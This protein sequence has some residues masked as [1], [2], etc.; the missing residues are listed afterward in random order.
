MGKLVLLVVFLF[1][2]TIFFKKKK[3]A[4][5]FENSSLSLAM[6]REPKKRF[7]FILS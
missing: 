3:K 6:F 4:V 1:L 5:K 2:P 7:N